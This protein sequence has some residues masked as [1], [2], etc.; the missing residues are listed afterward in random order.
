MYVNAP[1]GRLVILS[2][3]QTIDSDP[4]V[5]VHAAVLRVDG[6]K[7]PLHYY[8]TNMGVVVVISYNVNVSR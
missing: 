5:V 7:E 3:L 2:I 4:R 1:P 6:S 8:N